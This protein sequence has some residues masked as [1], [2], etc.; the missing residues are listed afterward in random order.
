MRSQAFL[1]W[2]QPA[3]DLLSGRGIEIGAFEQPAPLSAK[4]R[5]EYCDTVTPEQAQKLF[6]EISTAGFKKI[7]HLIDLN[8]EGLRPF[9]SASLDFV[10]INHVIEHLVNPIRAIHEII[11]VLRPGGIMV[12]GIPDR[13]YTFDRHRP[14]TSFA[15]LY[16][17]YTDNVTSASPEEYLDIPRY[18]FPEFMK[19]PIDDLREHLLGCQQRREHLHVWTSVSFRDFLDRTFTVIGERP[20]LLYEIDGPR[21]NLEYFG[22]W[23]RSYP[24]G[25]RG[26]I[27]RLRR[28][29]WK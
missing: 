10:I 5:V 3:Y 16:K 14:L 22:A 9:R 2:R 15:H 29:L 17:D 23:R 12:L 11:R 13:D 27:A 4:C 8:T 6:P 1:S 24:R 20:Q 19:L 26:L 28:R 7:D 18:I 21:T 25:V